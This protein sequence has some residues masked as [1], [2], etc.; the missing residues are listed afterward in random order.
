MGR[1]KL[2][3]DVRKNHERKKKLYQAVTRA[4]TITNDFCIWLPIKTAYLPSRVGSVNTL[5]E[6][7]TRL[8]ALPV[9]G[10]PQLSV[11]S[12]LLSNFALANNF[13]VPTVLYMVTISEDFT[14]NVRRGENTVRSAERLLE[15]IDGNKDKATVIASSV[16]SNLDKC[17]PKSRSPKAARDRMWGSF[18][19]C[20][21]NNR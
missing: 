2:R 18:T 4:V 5:H 21:E 13:E 6:R 7:V 20:H 15:W 14:W 8:G 9:D 12:W 3:F 1:R 16:I 10:L 11:G 17:F 19:P